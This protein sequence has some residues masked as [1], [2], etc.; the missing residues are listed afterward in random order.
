MVTGWFVRHRVA[1]AIAALGLLSIPAFLIWETR[2]AI[3]QARDRT[4][5]ASSIRATIRP[6]DR[7]LPAEVEPVGAQSVFRDAALFH[8]HL[9]VAGPQG[10]VEYDENGAVLQRFRTGLELPASGLVG[11]LTVGVLAA[12]SEPELLIATAAEGLLTSTVAECFTSG[13]SCRNHGS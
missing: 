10:L 6:L 1:A 2:Q 5:S 4:E 12:A 3:R 13:R 9:F 11:P 8:G 7:P